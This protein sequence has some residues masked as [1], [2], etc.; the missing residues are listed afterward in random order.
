VEGPAEGDEVLRIAGA[1]AAMKIKSNHGFTWM[2]R[3]RLEVR[4]TRA[5][6]DCAEGVDR[7]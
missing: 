7:I 5:T 4:K 1:G 6:G 3:I 2:T